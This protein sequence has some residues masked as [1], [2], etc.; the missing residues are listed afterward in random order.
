MNSAKWTAFAIGYQCLLAYAV[1][2]MIY[3]F[4][5]ALSGGASIFGLV[6]AASVAAFIVF[7]IVKKPY[8]A[9]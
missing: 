1:S 5:M 3:Q 2:L 4:G 9:K 8:K 7:M 6:L